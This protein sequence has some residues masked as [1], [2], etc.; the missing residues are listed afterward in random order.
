MTATRQRGTM[1]HVVNMLGSASHGASGKMLI[2]K[3]IQTSRKTFE[4]TT[5]SFIM[6]SNVWILW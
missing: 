4:K 5:H 6:H 3:K 2:N 1:A